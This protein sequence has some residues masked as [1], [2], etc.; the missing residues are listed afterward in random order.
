MTPILN[1]MEAAQR[2][3]RERTHGAKNPSATIFV[4]RAFID[5]LAATCKPADAIAMDKII[6]DLLNG[7]AAFVRGVPIYLDESLRLGFIVL[8]GNEA[9]LRMRDIHKRRAA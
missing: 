1:L 8:K 3:L 6:N 5:R 2:V 4:S 7:H 9:S